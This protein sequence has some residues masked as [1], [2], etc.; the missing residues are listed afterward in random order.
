MNNEP[1][2]IKFSALD[3]R[4]KAFTLGYR[5]NIAI[6]GGDKE[7]TSYLLDNYLSRNKSDEL[8]YLYTSSAYAGK[9]EFFKA[10]AFSL[11]SDYT[12]K[13]E[14]LDNLINC[15]SPVLV[16]TTNFIKDCLKK[17]NISFL[18]VLETINKFI[19]E[20]NRNCVLII[21][22]FLNLAGIFKNFYQVFSKFIIIQR[23]CMVVLTA[24]NSRDAEKILS[25]ELNLLFGNFEK[26]FLNENAS[27]AN[28][29]YFKKL[30]HPLTPSPLF[31]SFFVNIFGANII[32]YDL[33]VQTIKDNYQ[34]KDEEA[35]I[36]EIIKKTFYSKETYLFQKFIKK[37]DLIKFYFKDSVPVLKLLFALGQ[38][39]LRKKKLTSLGIYNSKDLNNRLQKLLD[40]NYIENLGNI[41]KIRDPLF[42]FWL[43]SVFKLY[44]SPPVL[45]PQ[46]KQALLKEELKEKFTLFKEEFTKDKLKKVMQLF[47]SFKDDTLRL[48]KNKYQLPTVENA[49][50]I[51]YPTRDFHL[52]IGEGKEIVFAG[53]KEKNVE[54]NDI[55]DFI[56]K[57]SNIKGKKVKKI[58]V[59]LDTLPPTARLIAKNNKLTIWDI[60]EINRLLTVYNKPIVSSEMETNKQ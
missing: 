19:N 43:T 46:H 14:S 53:I 42:S 44:F 22:E 50:V 12:C 58:F 24:S 32:Y 40:L 49:K 28:Y 54:D 8:T 13:S 17:E 39:Y 3:K 59:S 45:N 57:G 33:I 16:S 20:S 52:L 36:I 31:L 29:F 60:D 10:I 38:G 1:W 47:S 37:I 7:E 35:S 48:G 15:A 9:K 6:L 51:S 18:D 4:V 26:V 2:T 25:G 34:A 55:F 56:E 11:L 41:Y 23:N 21:E 5:Q 27:L 30:L